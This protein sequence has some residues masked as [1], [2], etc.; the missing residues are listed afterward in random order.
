MLVV[1]FYFYLTYFKKKYLPLVAVL[2]GFVTVRI[3]SALMIA[4]LKG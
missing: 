2:V 3:L 1:M 4:S